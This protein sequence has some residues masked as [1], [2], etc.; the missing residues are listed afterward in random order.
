MKNS[1]GFTLIELLAVIVV[2]ATIALITTPMIMNVIENARK[3]AFKDSVLGVFDALDYYLIDNS[4]PEEG[5][6]VRSLNLSKNQ[7]SGMIIKNEEGKYEAV[8]I[9]DGRYCASGEETNL[10]IYKGECDATYGVIV[11]YNVDGTTYEELVNVGSSAT[12]P[13]SFTPSKSDWSFVG[14]RQDTVAS[15]EV[16][17]DLIVS[18]EPITLYAVFEQDVTLSYDAN[19]GSGTTASET[20]QRYDNN[21]TISDPTFTVKANGFSKSNQTFVRWRLNSTSGTEYSAGSSITLSE[22]AVMYAEWTLSC[23]PYTIVSGGVSKMSVTWNNQVG[24]SNQT[25]TSQSWWNGLSANIS[26][27]LINNTWNTTLIVLS[28]PF[29]ANGCT[30]LKMQASSFYS[31]SVNAATITVNGTTK[32][33]NASSGLVEFNISG[34][35]TFDIYINLGTVWAYNGSPSIT[36]SSIYVE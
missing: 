6:S 17:D 27:S 15:A 19:G 13:T 35:T 11:T 32:T 2:L 21:G 31:S 33:V 22:N 30:K 10:I 14:W 12:N 16:L 26:Q 18:G 28:T 25:T 9:S 1:T 4:I 7:L 29:E 34:T 8:S 3:E 24:S 23:Q 20:K 36:F 5:I